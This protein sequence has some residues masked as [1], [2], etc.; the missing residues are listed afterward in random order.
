MVSTK[1]G[2]HSYDTKMVRLKEKARRKLH[3]EEDVLH[4]P[5]TNMVF[6]FKDFVCKVLKLVFLHCKPNKN[7]PVLVFLLRRKEKKK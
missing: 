5:Q 7:D 4:S 2:T 1:Q 3:V 6:V